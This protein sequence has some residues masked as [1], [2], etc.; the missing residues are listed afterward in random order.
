[1]LGAFARFIPSLFTAAPVRN[2][3]GNVIGDTW[4]SIKTNGRQ[5]IMQVVGVKDPRKVAAVAANLQKSPL[6]RGKKRPRPD[7]DYSD[8]SYIDS[9]E[10]VE[11]PNAANVRRRGVKRM[12][13]V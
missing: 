13:V 12:R 10:Y 9:Y 6:L 4:N 3:V 5:A 1:M 11:T 2:F 8:E 7:D